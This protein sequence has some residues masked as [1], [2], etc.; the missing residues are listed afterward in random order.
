M[1]PG[2]AQSGRGSSGGDSVTKWCDGRH[3]HAGAQECG[4]TRRSALIATQF[5]KRFSRI[6]SI[7][8]T[9][10]GPKVSVAGD[11][12]VSQPRSES[13]NMF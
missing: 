9:H 6:E 4:A 13:S 7:L 1:D 8:H 12:D 2:V 5:T 3:H 10:P 11:A